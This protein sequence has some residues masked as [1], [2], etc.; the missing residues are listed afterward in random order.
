MENFVVPFLFILVFIFLC[1]T[2]CLTALGSAF[3]RMNKRK[4]KQQLENLGFSFFY[5]PFHLYFFP[6]HEF[7]GIFFS[8]ICAQNITR[9][10][11]GA[12]VVFLLLN[13]GFSFSLVENSA[14]FAWP[15]TLLAMIFAILIGFLIGEFIPRIW[16]R[17]FPEK[18]LF[19]SAPA[20]LFLFLSFPICYPFL[21]F[22]QSLSHMVYFDY[23]YEPQAQIK[24][25]IIELIHETEIPS[26]LDPVDKKLIQS[27]VSFPTRLAREIMVP[28]VDLF[29]LS[30]DISI[31][32]AARLLE[33]E[34]YSRIPVYSNSI[35]NIVGILMYKDI[36][37]KYME[38]EEKGNDAS[39]LEKPIETIVKSILYAPETKKISHLLQEFRKKQVHLAIVVDEYGGT[40]GL[41]TIEDI[42]EEIVG[43]IADEY[44]EEAEAF[45][46]QHDGSLVVDARMNILDAEEQLG[47]RIPQEG[48][49]DTVGGYIYHRA[50][51]IPDKGF[52]IYH[53]DFKLE[54]LKSSERS[55]E[56]VRITPIPVKN[57]D[58]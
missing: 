33:T 34:G 30:S 1:G 6:F 29:S 13:L 40:E 17:K 23:L 44:D 50:G 2:F 55:V 12:T 18:A 37:R 46:L 9:F 48:D 3:R 54:V 14:V 16:G 43:E 11:Y 57:Q 38:Y 4:S 31:K 19:F 15:W 45:T 58:Q 53:D 32:K 41:V 36:L 20:S 7:E 27:V 51:T 25:E 21:R 28:R 5:R 22:S 24:Q 42:L 26:A 8:V 52:V 10:C 56:K 35:D 49:Y 39:I 47:V